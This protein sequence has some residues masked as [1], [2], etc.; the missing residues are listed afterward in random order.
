MK[1][2]KDT[3]TQSEPVA[4]TSNNM[5][6]TITTSD[7]ALR[8]PPYDPGKQD[9]N[10]KI[11][12]LTQRTTAMESQSLDK[13]HQQTKKKKRRKKRKKGGNERRERRNAKPQNDVV[14]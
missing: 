12:N 7:S 1:T 13:N 14:Q 2:T 9:D 3:Q 11:P 4:M 6:E 8:T 10:D 5:Q